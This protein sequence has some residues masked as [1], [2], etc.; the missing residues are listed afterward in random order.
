MGQNMTGSQYGTP[1]VLATDKTNKYK[2]NP[3]LEVTHEPE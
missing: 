1:F 3:R 2:I